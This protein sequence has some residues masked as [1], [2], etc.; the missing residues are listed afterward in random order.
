MHAA[1]YAFLLLLGLSA[2]FLGLV[3]YNTWAEKR[4]LRQMRRDHDWRMW[5]SHVRDRLEDI[6]GSAA[7]CIIDREKEWFHALW[8]FGHSAPAA[9]E[10][11]FAEK[12]SVP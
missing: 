3:C 11:W 7:T 12:G 2:F 4:K 5:I 10:K 9:V 1:L 8:E 6:E